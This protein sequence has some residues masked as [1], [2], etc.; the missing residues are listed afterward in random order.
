MQKDH[1]K[2]PRVLDIF[3]GAG[4]FSEG[5]RQAGFLIECGID[6]DHQAILTYSRNFPKSI[7]LKWDL[8]QPLGSSCHEFESVSKAGIDVIVGGPPCQGFSIAG[9]RVLDDPRNSLYKAYFGL[10][11]QLNPNAVVVE[12]VPTILTLYKGAVADAIT[13]EFKLR[14]YRVATFVL[15]ASDFGI[16]QNRRRVFFVATRGQKNFTIPSADIFIEKLT[17]ADAISD[18]PLLESEPGAD[19]QS[20]TTEPKTAYQK[21]MRTGSNELFNHWAVMHTEKTK[22]II[23]QVPDGGNYKSLPKSLWDTRKVNIAWTRMH[24]NSPCFTIDAGHNHHFHYKANRVPTVRECARIQS[25][26]DRFQFLGNKT[27]QF[28][29]VGNAVPPLLA[30][31]IGQNLLDTFELTEN[32]KEEI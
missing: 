9:K 16:P 18:L 22:K 31:I 4:G 28:R 27:S 2:S 26:P 24:S 30:K 8:H 13:H 20:Y 21:L 3:C 1:T 5:F 7:S 15:L 17:C 19:V 14:G 32:Q 10:I 11:E 23:A 29:Q 6:F 25:F 12:N